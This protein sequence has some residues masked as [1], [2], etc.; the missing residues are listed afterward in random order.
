MLDLDLH[1]PVFPRVC[2]D[3]SQHLLGHGD[4]RVIFQVRYLA[5]ARLA[6]D[7]PYER[8][9]GSVGVARNALLQ[10]SHIDRPANDTTHTR[11][12]PAHRWNEGHLV[13]F[14]EES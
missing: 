12:S 3:Q 9:D 5:A 6:S 11:L 2:G 4:V 14:D 13:S 7:L 1:A 8:Q 10:R